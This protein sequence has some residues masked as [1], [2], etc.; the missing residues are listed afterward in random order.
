MILFRNFITFLRVPSFILITFFFFTYTSA[1]TL[2]P[3]LCIFAIFLFT[4]TFT[5]GRTPNL[6][7]V[8]VFFRAF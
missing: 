7:I 1:S 6:R 3:N 2:V 4:N 5:L 8:T